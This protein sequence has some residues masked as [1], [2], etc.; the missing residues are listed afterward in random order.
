MSVCVTGFD[1]RSWTV[2][3]FVDTY[4]LGNDCN[5]SV[6]RIAQKAETTTRQPENADIHLQNNDPDGKWKRIMVDPI[7]LQKLNADIPIWKPWEYFFRV[8]GYRVE[9]VVSEWQ[10]VEFCI[11]QETNPYVRRIRKRKSAHH[12]KDSLPIS[13]R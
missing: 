8:L 4:Y 3:A 10:D 5:E 12:F 1:E 2:W 6:T 9:R 11:L 13:S 7:S